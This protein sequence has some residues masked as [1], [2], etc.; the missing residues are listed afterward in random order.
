MGFATRPDDTGECWFEPAD[1]VFGA[2]D[3]ARQFLLRLGS[4]NAAAPT[5]KHGVY[6][7]FRVPKNYVGTPMVVIEW[8]G[9]LTSGNV[10]F[11]FD[12]T[13]VGGD[14]AETFDPAAWQESVTVTDAVAGTAR[15]KSTPTVA[16][17][18]GN[19]AVDDIVEF[20]FG[21]D[22][23]DGADTMA[24]SAWV[25]ELILQYADA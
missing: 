15:F 6:G 7:S 20:F 11:D 23:A 17:T 18:G 4:N 8:V 12:Y 9:T 13:A 10:V 16:I 2:N 5:V 21:R 14:G 1:L 22:G 25:A 3:L 19:L 24:G